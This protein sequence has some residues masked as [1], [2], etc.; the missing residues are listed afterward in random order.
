M[1]QRLAP[2]V[3]RDM[4][5]GAMLETAIEKEPKKENR[6]SVIWCHAGISRRIVVNGYAK[7]LDGVLASYGENLFLDLSWILSRY[8]MSSFL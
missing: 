2:A 4:L 7:I 8:A 3:P 5:L 6:P 1:Y